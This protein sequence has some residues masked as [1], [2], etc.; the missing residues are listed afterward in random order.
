MGWRG[1]DGALHGPAVD[2]SADYFG[3]AVTW[4]RPEEFV[5]LMPNGGAEPLLILDPQISDQ[6]RKSAFR[7]RAWMPVVRSTT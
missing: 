2:D 7:I 1:R 3:E 6:G 5:A 4:H